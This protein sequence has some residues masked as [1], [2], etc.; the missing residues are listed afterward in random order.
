VLWAELSTSVEMLLTQYW[1]EGALRGATSAEAFTVRCD[2]S[3]MTQNDI[4][5]GRVLVEVTLA[6]AAAIEHISIVL[7]LDPAGVAS[8]ALREAA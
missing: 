4:D 2:R 7:A 5:N 6:P 1:R 3:T 8:V